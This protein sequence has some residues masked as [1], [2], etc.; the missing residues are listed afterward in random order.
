[1]IMGWP[2]LQATVVEKPLSIAVEEV[3][4]GLREPYR[5]RALKAQSI[6]AA[7]DDEPMSEVDERVNRLVPRL[8]DETEYHWSMRC[9]DWALEQLRRQP[10]AMREPGQDG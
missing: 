10:E 9:R 6:A 7:G 5:T 1:M 3:T 4:K 2:A 8:A